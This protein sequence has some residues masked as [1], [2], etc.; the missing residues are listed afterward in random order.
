MKKYVQLCSLIYLLTNF[1]NSGALGSGVDAWGM[2]VL[3]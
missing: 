3:T 2:S 1:E